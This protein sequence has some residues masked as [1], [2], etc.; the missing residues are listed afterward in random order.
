MTTPNVVKRPPPNKVAFKEP[1]KLT[2]TTTPQDYFE[3]S[4]FGVHRSFWQLQDYGRWESQYSTRSHQGFKPSPPQDPPTPQS[5]TTNTTT[6]T[7]YQDK[8]KGKATQESNAMTEYPQVLSADKGHQR[9]KES[10]DSSSSPTTT[11]SL[12]VIETTSTRHNKVYQPK[13]PSQR[14]QHKKPR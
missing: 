3:K 7:T 11:E 13:Y 4:S 2:V 8:D 9:I 12:Q 10:I 6:A 5:L 1:E 14:F